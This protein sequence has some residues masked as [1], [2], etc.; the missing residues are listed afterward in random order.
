MKIVRLLLIVIVALLSIAAG[1]AKVIQAPQEMEF[2]QG[3][4]LSTL[5]IIV[6]GLVQILA[7]V[8]LAPQKTRISGATLAIIAFAASTILIFKGGNFAFALFSILPIVLSV[9]VVYQTA[10]M[11]LRKPE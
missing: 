4:G 2:L 3:F 5:S 8:L 1:A 9:I 11:A 10:D 6:F 7:G